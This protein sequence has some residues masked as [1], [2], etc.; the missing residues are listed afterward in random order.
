[1]QKIL[2]GLRS[3]LDHVKG[4]ELAR[5][6]DS[7][8]DYCIRQLTLAHVR[9]DVAKVQEAKELMVQIRDAWEIMP[10]NRAAPVQ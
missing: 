6:L 10:L 4:G 5:N 8:Y 9:N 3:T 2:F 7:L 1:A